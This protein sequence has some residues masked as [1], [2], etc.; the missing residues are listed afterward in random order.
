MELFPFPIQREETLRYLGYQGQPLENSLLEK[1]DLARERIRRVSRPLCIF[2][3]FPIHR[4]EAGI[5]PSGTNLLLP[6]KDIENHLAG[7]SQVI[8]MAATLGVQADKEIKYLALADIAL[9]TIADAAA[10]AAVEELCDWVESSIRREAA[11]QGLFATGRFSPGY[12]DLPISLQREFTQVLD[13]PKAIGLTVSGSGIL[14]PRKSVTAIL[15]L[16]SEPIAAPGRS[17]TSCLNRE[18]CPYRTRGTFGE[19]DKK[20]V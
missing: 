12:G 14:L 3:A 6:G 4:T 7:C 18:S 17:C 2:R 5:F 15:G 10:T 19:P 16:S 1:L 11:N 9:G 20:T 13:T 8:L